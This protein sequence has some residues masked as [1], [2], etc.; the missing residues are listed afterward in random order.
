MAENAQFEGF[1]RLTGSVSKVERALAALKKSG[2]EFEVAVDHHPPFPYPGMIPHRPFPLPGIIARLETAAILQDT[3]FVKRQVAA[4]NRG[5]PKA[6]QIK[7]QYLP[8]WGVN[9]GRKYLHLHLANKILPL[10]EAI[11]SGMVVA[12]QKELTRIGAGHQI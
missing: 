11:F 6:S 3:K 5:L 4:L 1:V 9:G 8:D 10:N 2:A 12:A 7:L